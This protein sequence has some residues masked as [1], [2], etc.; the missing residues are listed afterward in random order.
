MIPSKSLKPQRG[1]GQ[2]VSRQRRK[3]NDQIKR[4]EQ[5]R[6]DAE[7][8]GAR[9]VLNRS[10]QASPAERAEA[11]WKNHILKATVDHQTAVMKSYGISLPVQASIAQNTWWNSDSGKIEAY[12]DFTSIVMKFPKKMFP[13][14]VTIDAQEITDVIAIIRGVFQHELGH[15]RFTTPFRDLP[16][17][18]VSTEGVA[19]RRIQW[20]WNCV[21]DQR[22][23]QAV[24]SGVPRL[25]TYFTQ[26]VAEHILKDDSQERSWLL[27]SG[28]TYL[29]V[30]V[31][32]QSRALFAQKFGE[33]RADKWDELVT[34][35][36]GATSHLDMAH[37][38]VKCAKFIDE[39]GDTPSSDSGSI[40]EHRNYYNRSESID[41]S[42]SATDINNDDIDG[43]DID[44]EQGGDKYDDK[45]DNEQGDG[46]TASPDADG[47][48][49]IDSDT[50]QTTD[51]NGSATGTTSGK[52]VTTGKV[53]NDTLRDILQKVADEAL[54]EMKHDATNEQIARDAHELRNSASGFLPL[55]T[56]HRDEMS[57]DHQAEAERLANGMQTALN[58][59]VTASQPTWHSH[60]ERGV[61]DPI[62]YRTK[63]V[64]D[65]D[66]RRNL[67]GD[68][69]GGLDVHVS[70][71]CDASGSMDGHAMIALS[72]V[73]YATNK[74]CDNLGIGM[75]SVLWSSYGDDYRI[76]DDEAR[77]PA[78]YQTLG[79]TDPT[80]ALDD[81]DNHNPE[82][83][84]NHLVIIFTDGEWDS[85]FP[86]CQQWSRPNRH[87]VLINYTW[88]ASGL[89]AR[90][91]DEVINTNK[92]LNIP[93]EMT[94]AIASILSR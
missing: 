26:M 88:Y 7:R 3:A 36:V 10:R 71:L 45:S 11:M 68:V 44:G 21:E 69:A 83:A 76:A 8:R 58:D 13:S 29:P 91:C 25:G 73:I 27:L 57:A 4:E 41:P 30:L 24:V 9:E 14:K 40:D 35:Y 20:A 61:L 80:T 5:R 72:Q 84:S 34:A 62:A 49:D 50:S 94:S 67:I 79:G 33:Y 74:A 86:G 15:I 55:L 37:I 70:L 42:D 38:V 63:S 1:L 59:F 22:M 18:A 39:L 89:D 16:W 92:I 51:G 46:E 6:R 17:G 87:M 31:R 66:Y 90:G 81:L 52:G 60:Q 85:T 19:E 77:I 82:E 48:K 56:G 12:T 47:Q 65:L 64:G 54:Q 32:K 53:D 2:A 93:A 23:E 43:D 78:V 28:R 75:T